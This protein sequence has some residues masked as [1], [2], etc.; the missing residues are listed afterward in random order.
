MC[1]TALVC[2]QINKPSY[3]IKFKRNFIWMGNI[4][5]HFKASNPGNFFPATKAIKAPPLKLIWSIF[6]ILYLAAAVLKSPPPI[7]LNPLFFSIALNISLVPLLK[8][9]KSKFPA[10]PFIN[11]T[12]AFLISSAYFLIVSLPISSIMYLLGNSF[13]F[14]STLLFSIFTAKSLGI[15]T[16]F[17][18]FFSLFLIFNLSFRNLFWAPKLTPLEIRQ[19][20]PNSPQLKTFWPFNNKILSS[21]LAPPKIYKAFLIF[22][23]LKYLISFSKFNP[24]KLFNFL[25]KPTILLCFL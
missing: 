5:C 4:F 7:T 2:P 19:I 15:S 11:I 9:F 22:N 17:S 1:L 3:L 6:L 20:C 8:F 16:F 10:G 21:A 14:N 12:L 25:G 18:L 23:L 24:I 13:N